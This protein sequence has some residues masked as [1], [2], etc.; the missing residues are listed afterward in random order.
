MENNQPPRPN[1]Y[2]A[3]SIISTILCCL[4]TG[5]VSIIYST[6]VNTKY[7]AGDYAGAEQASKNAKTWALVG[8]IAGAVIILGYF[9]IFGAAF[10][11]EMSR[12][13]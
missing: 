6:Q 7:D 1:N 10:F 2:L 8:I 5:I 13:Y 3:L 9:L 11:S 4:V 12:G